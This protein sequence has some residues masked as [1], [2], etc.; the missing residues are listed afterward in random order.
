MR[1][2]LGCIKKSVAL[3][4]LLPG[5]MASCGDK[6]KETKSDYEIAD[7]EEVSLKETDRTLIIDN[8]DV[9]GRAAGVKV[10]NDSVLSVRRIR[11]EFPVMLYNIANKQSV[12]G[13]VAGEGPEE[14]VS[15]GALSS[16]KEGNLWLFGRADQKVLSVSW[17][18]LDSLP[19]RTFHYKTPMLILGGAPLPDGDVFVMPTHENDVR[20]AKLDKNGQ[21]IGKIQSFPDLALPNDTLHLNNSMMQSDLSI[22]PD[23][24]HILVACKS[25][26]SI[27]IIEEP[28]GRETLLNGPSN[29]DVEIISKETPSGRYFVQ[30]PMLFM[31]DGEAAGDD[32]F[33][34][35]YVGVEPKTDDDFD[36]HI[37]SLLEFDWSGKPLRRFVF[38]K[39]VMAFDIDFKNKRVYTL[40][41]TPEPTIWCYSLSGK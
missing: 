15:V 13:V 28:T 10:L 9:L 33:F 19:V 11:S 22:S 29:I 2:F 3:V 7:F 18:G 25:L 12:V 41:N 14:L 39:D 21:E 30:Q 27:Q 37:N 32:S 26:P 8:V 1:W 23:G 24:K 16:D 6:A 38:E 5:L 17:N 20:L 35:G 34:V 4:S 40:E 36:K 31:F